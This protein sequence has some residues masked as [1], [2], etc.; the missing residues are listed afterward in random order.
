MDAQSLMAHTHQGAGA[1]T[2]HLHV[3]FHPLQSPYLC[4]HPHRARIFSVHWPLRN[5]RVEGTIPIMVG[6]RHHQK[7]NVTYPDLGLLHSIICLRRNFSELVKTMLEKMWF[8]TEKKGNDNEGLPVTYTPS[9][10]SLTGFGFC[11][12]VQC[13]ET[14]F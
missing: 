13:S 3:P 7:M 8:L 6:K 14:D 11:K 1:A 9:N 2:V 5:C 4:L 10:T 12:L